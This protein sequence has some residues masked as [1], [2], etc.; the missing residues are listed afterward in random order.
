MAAYASPFGY[1]VDRFQREAAAVGRVRY[2]YGGVQYDAFPRIVPV[3]A[4][5]FQRRSFTL[6]WPVSVT[7][8]IGVAASPACRLQLGAWKALRVWPLAA[9]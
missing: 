8:V 1:I 2:L 5:Q 9:A 7:P 3:L 4:D 6:G